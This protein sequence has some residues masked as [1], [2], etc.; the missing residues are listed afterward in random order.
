MLR[1]IGSSLAAALVVS[2]SAQAQDKAIP[3]VPVPAKAV[4][5]A[6]VQAAPAHIAPLPA[7]PIQ[8]APTP[9]RSAIVPETSH[10]VESGGCLNG[11]CGAERGAFQSDTAFPDF[12]GPL[13]NVFF[14]KDPRAQTYLRGHY[15]YNRLPGDHA[16]GG[17]SVNA[18]ALQINV[19]VNDRLTIIADKDGYAWLDTPGTGSRDGFMNLGVGFKYALIRDVENQFLFTVGAMYEPRTG[20]RDVFQGHGDGLITFFGTLGKEFGCKNHAIVNVG[21][22]VPFNSNENSSYIYTQLHLDRQIAGWLY[23]LIELNWFHYTSSGD[24]GLPPVVGEGDGLINLGTSGVAGNNL[25]TLALGAQMRL[26][27]N[28][29]VGVGYEFPISSRKDLLDDRV[30]VQFTLR[31]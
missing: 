3:A 25:V 8:G 14:A 26:R 28:L 29:D 17:G 4:Q 9:V 20:S 23:P 30:Y 5:V 21:Y 24:R 7:A 6:P 12:V 13:S 22:Q 1:F 11:N 31:Y 15:I 2:G 18:V 10:W 16:L 19:A 27:E